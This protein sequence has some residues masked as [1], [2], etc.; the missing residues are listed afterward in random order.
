M[1]RVSKPSEALQKPLS[2]LLGS[3]L[4]L[5]ATHVPG[6]ALRGLLGP[7]FAGRSGGLAGLNPDRKQWLGTQELGLLRLAQGWGATHVAGRGWSGRF[8]ASEGLPGGFLGVRLGCPEGQ[9][10]RAPCGTLFR[11]LASR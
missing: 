2:A 9:K 6:G 11:R 7:I 4:G 8:G 3:S 5:S 10:K 1:P